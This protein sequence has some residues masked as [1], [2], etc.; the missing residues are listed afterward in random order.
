MSNEVGPKLPADFPS[1]IQDGKNNL[2]LTNNSG[3]TVNLNYYASNDRPSSSSEKLIAIQSFSKDYYQLIVTQEDDV[4]QT[5]VI[6]VSTDRAL[7]KRYVPEE[8]FERCSSLSAEGIE[9]LKTFPAVICQENTEHHGITSPNQWAMYS[10][11]RKVQVAGG[12]V[13]IAFEP[14]QPFP[15][16]KMCGKRAAV[17]FDLVMDCAIT[18]LNHSAWSVH[19]ANLFDAFKEVGLIDMPMPI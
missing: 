1:V 17:F 5:N 14:I 4:F 9:L 16:I 18:D 13:K 10:Y 8:I 3:G 2:N 7:A 11:I 6:T 12:N 15:Q 19:R